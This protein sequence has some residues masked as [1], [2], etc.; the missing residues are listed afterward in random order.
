MSDVSRAYA[1]VQSF[2]RLIGLRPPPSATPYE[3]AARISRA[4]PDGEQAVYRITR[5][6]AEEQYAQPRDRHTRLKASAG[7][8]S[9]WS[10]LRPRFLRRIA[11]RVIGWFDPRPRRTADPDEDVPG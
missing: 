11:L 1:R 6:Y 10:R 5:L 7:A 2:A 4:L 3:R 8:R 9:A